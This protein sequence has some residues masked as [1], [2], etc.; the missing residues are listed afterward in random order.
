MDVAVIILGAI[1]L[2]VL[3]WVVAAGR[4]LRGTSVS[5]VLSPG[6]RISSTPLL[7]EMDLFFYNVIRLAVQDH[8]LV[9]AQVPL[10]AFVSVEAPGQARTEVLNRIALKRVDFVLV[11][12]GSRQVEQVVQ[13][14]ESAARPHQAERQRVIASICDAAGIKL[15]KI[16]PQKSYSTRDMAALL[17]FPPED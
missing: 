1:V 4:R 8:F 10:W 7:S 15:V 5:P 11:H 3:L 12:P 17:G 13:I 16:C 6:V 2:F 14:E 9:F